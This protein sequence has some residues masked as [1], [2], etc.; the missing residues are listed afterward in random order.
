MAELRDELGAWI[1]G[2]LAPAGSFTTKR[3]GLSHRAGVAEKTLGAEEA[4]RSLAPGNEAL[5]LFLGL[6]CHPP[7]PG[8]ALQRSTTHSGVATA[9]VFL[10]V[11]AEEALRSLNPEPGLSKILAVEIKALRSQ[12]SVPGRSGYGAPAGLAAFPAEAVAGLGN[13]ALP[14]FR[15]SVAIRP[16]GGSAAAGEAGPGPGC[17]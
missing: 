2:A 6:A 10:V 3:F 1:E 4:L 12:E 5:P 17:K 11:Q 16:G 15:V 9:S 7:R 8:E 13:E 14:L